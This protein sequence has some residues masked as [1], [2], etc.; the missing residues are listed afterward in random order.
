[1]AIA[2]VTVLTPILIQDT[3]LSQSN[4][5]AVAWVDEEDFSDWR[6]VNPLSPAVKIDDAL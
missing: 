4:Q 6:G 5:K 3:K 2:F 1:M